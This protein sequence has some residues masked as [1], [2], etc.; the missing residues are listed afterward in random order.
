MLTGIKDLDHIILNKLDD[1]DL[2]NVCQTNK[3]ADE[4]CNDQVFWL[5]RIKTKFP[6]LTMDILNKYKRGRTWSDY[7]IKDL[8][9]IARIPANNVIVNGAYAERLDWIIE[10]LKNG[11]DINTYLGNYPLIIAVDAGNL[12][13]VKYLVEHGAD[14]H[15]V[16]D[17]PL[18]SASEHGY[19]DIVKYLVEKGANINDVDLFT[20]PLSLAGEN[21]HL[22]VIKYL[23]ENGADIRARD[24]EAIRYVDSYYGGKNKNEIIDYL[25]SLGA[26]RP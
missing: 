22:D 13:I 21:G 8:I 23:V 10:G 12:D 14:I 26:P 4:I 18:R 7:Y 24:D 5:N 9:K 19:L 3:K 20:K 16:H 1:K 6:E 11:A 2:V 25:V 15:I 17:F